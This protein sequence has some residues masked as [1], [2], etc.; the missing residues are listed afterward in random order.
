MK[1]TDD[2]IADIGEEIIR[3]LKTVYDPEIPVDIYEL[4][5][6]YDVQISDEADVKIIMTLTS[7][8]CPVAE[9]LPQEVKD[10][11]KEVE[12]VNEVDL[13]LTFEPTWNKDMMSEE[14]KFELGML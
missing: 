10:K 9:S 12:N 11:V 6:I 14:A 5:L 4:G 7:P 13:E 3:I 2:Q 1:F 8:N